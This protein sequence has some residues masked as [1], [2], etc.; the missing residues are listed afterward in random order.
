MTCIKYK[1]FKAITSNTNL[2][3][4]PIWYIKP[5]LYITS[6]LVTPKI[7]LVFFQIPFSNN[8][9]FMCHVEP[10]GAS[11][12]GEKIIMGGEA[13]FRLLPWQRLKYLSLHTLQLRCKLQ[14]AH[15]FLSFLNKIRFC[16]EESHSRKAIR[17]FEKCLIHGF[18]IHIQNA[19]IPFK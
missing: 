11:F 1:F 17:N 4:F 2:L 15:S 3:I 5:I 16:I 19:Q 12:L 6:I 7:A 18:R 13:I 9:S 8:S 14:K 10:A